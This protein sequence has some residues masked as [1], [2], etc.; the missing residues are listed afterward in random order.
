M[1]EVLRTLDGTMDLG[2]ITIQGIPGMRMVVFSALLMI[3]ILFYQ[4]GLMGTNEFRWE[5]VTSPKK[6]ITDAW[7]NRK[8]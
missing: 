8:A 2:F 6:T 1:L 5:W 7:N 4:R 3:V